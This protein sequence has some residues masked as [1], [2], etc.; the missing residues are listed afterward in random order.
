MQIAFTKMHGLG[1]DFVVINNMQYKMDFD[2]KWIK[3]LA[4]R[5]WGVGFDQMLI[6]EPP[7]SDNVEF[8]YRIFNADGAEVEHCGN[9][10]RCFA[11]FV[12]DKGLTTNKT[13]KVQTS[14]GIIDLIVNDDE[15]VTVR[16]G[17]PEFEPALIPFSAECKSSSYTLNLK[18]E[19]VQIGSLAIGNPHAVTLVSDVEAVDVIGLGSQITSHSRFPNRVNAGFMQIISADAIKLRVFERGVGE[20]LACGT[21]ACAA[22]V[23]GIVQGYLN[24]SVKVSLRGGDLYIH[25]DGINHNVLLTGPTATVF[26]GTITI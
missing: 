15:T 16:M 5:R 26:E 25:W 6:V 20:T 7:T 14:G 4:D 11:I 8:Q 12:R 9:G 17:V 1:N 3:R 24:N 2:Q 21:G 10:A 13:I 18:D 22:V 19:S 23:T